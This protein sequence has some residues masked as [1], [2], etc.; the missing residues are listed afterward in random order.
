MDFC[1]DVDAFVFVVNVES[2]RMG[3]CLSKQVDPYHL[4]H[5]HFLPF[6]PS[7]TTSSNQLSNCY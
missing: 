2:K 6:F 7:F 5:F 4:N 1:N 3:D